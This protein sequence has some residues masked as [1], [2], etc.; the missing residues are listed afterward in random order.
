MSKVSCFYFLECNSV[1][2]FAS[3]PR[4]CNFFILLSTLATSEEFKR[5]LQVN[6]YDN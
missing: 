2:I 5:L 1:K 6:K 4:G 3:F